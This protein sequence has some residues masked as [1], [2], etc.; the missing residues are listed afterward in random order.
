MDLHWLSPGDTSWQ[1]TPATLV[2]LMSIPRL[3]VLY[4]GVM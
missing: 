4:G 1:L 2:G 3:V